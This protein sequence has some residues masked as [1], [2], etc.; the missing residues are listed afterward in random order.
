MSLLNYRPLELSEL[1]QVEA[2]PKQALEP[3][4]KKHL[5]TIVLYLLARAP[6]CGYDIIRTVYHRYYTFLSQGTVYPLLYSLER[7][8]FLSVVKPGSPRSKVYALTEEGKRAAESRIND[9]ISRNTYSSRSGSEGQKFSQQPEEFLP[10]HPSLF[11]NA[12][13]GALL[14]LRFHG[15]H[16]EENPL[17][18]PL[19]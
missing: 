3:F 7:K 9:F 19:V 4:V 12:Q 2:I 17:R 5:E 6:M 10:A 15:H 13:E 11:E 16:H 8:G 14:Y 1:P 18:S